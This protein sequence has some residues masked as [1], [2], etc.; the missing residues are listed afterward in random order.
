L[1]A[2]LFDAQTK[3]DS[4]HAAASRLITLKGVAGVSH[5]LEDRRK[6]QPAEFTRSDLAVLAQLLQSPYVTI[7]VARIASEDMPSDEAQKVLLQMSAE[8]QSGST[9]TDA[10]RKFYTRYPDM[11]DRAKDPHSTRTLISYL[12]DGIVS[13]TGFDILTYYAA[14]NL[15]SDHLRKLFQ[16]KRG[17]HV[18]MAVDGIYLY[19]IVN[20]YEGAN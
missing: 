17:V 10:Y 8:L 1:V 13:P 20:H 12:Y 7:K 6:K 3:A 11:R 4:F 5:L 19:Q 16:S 14:E 9:W 2:V 15:P 18:L